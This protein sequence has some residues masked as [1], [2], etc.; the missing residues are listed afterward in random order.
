MG[1]GSDAP[2]M[3]GA[4][5]AA[6]G[7]MQIA[8][9]QWADYRDKFAPVL[10]DQMQDQ[11]DIG[12]DSYELARDQQEFQTG[13]T[14][15]YDDRYWN[16]QVPLEDQI[17]Q[18]ARE[19]DTDRER[20]RMAG[21]ARADV[22]QAFGAA[23]GGLRREMGRM[24]LNPSDPRYFAMNRQ[25]ASDKALATATAM[26]KTREAARQM[27]WSRRTDAAALGRGL[28]GF[29]GDS[30]R[31][32][33]GWG[34]QGMQAG[35]MGMQGALGAVGGMNST[36]TSA[37]NNFSGAGQTFTNIAGIKQK[38]SEANSQ[39]L[40]TVAGAAGSMAMMSDRRLKTDIVRVGTLDSGIAVYS[41]RYK[42]GGP[43]MIGVMADEVERVLPAAVVKNAMGMYDAVDYSMLS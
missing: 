28:P 9:E 16:V 30:S 37:G 38:A 26:N 34:G 27:G 3:S 40:G 6:V 43:A 23:Q 22:E 8:K 32:A 19:F 31:V 1:W 25:M 5:E 33:M 7:Q 20:E 36:A 21:T 14:R 42:A 18:E 24:G 41:F 35:G 2:D 29:S 13:L 15:K 11:I 4:N 39:M 17:V 12:R 10:L